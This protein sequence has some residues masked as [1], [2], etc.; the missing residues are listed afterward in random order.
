MKT[1]DLTAIQVHF[2][3]TTFSRESFASA[4]DRYVRLACGLW[5]GER[6]VTV[7]PEFFPTFLYPAFRGM[8]LKGGPGKILLKYALKNTGLSL[9]PLRQAFL[10]HALEI[11]LFYRKTF[12]AL[13]GEFKTYLLAPSI[14]MP[15][16]DFESSRG[17]F[18]RDKRLYNMAYLFSP[19]GRL[20]AKIAKRNL[21]DAESRILFSRGSSFGNIAET[22]IG[23]LGVAICYDMFFESE[24]RRLD[25]SGCEIL[26]VPSCNFAPWKAHLNGS[27]QERVW[28]RDG[29][30]S[31]SKDRENIRFLVNAMAVGDIGGQTAQGRSSIWH[32]GKV[33]AISREVEREDVVNAIVELDFYPGGL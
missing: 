23:T 13:A 32:N 1:I 30:I 10:N 27:T 7:F 21:T 26:L 11:E 19:Q 20:I 18:L 17:T 3:A 8:T 5:R 15:E 4:M 31:A 14:L 28:F 29:P 16:V 9:N 25:S 33:L 24:V 2:D 6:H 22:S 12:G